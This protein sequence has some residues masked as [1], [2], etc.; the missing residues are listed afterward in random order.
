MDRGLIFR[1]LGQL[2]VAFT[3]ILVIPLLAALIEDFEHVML[4][5]WSILCSGILA[6]IFLSV[7]GSRT[8]Q[9]LR[10]REAVAVVGCGWLLVC[11]LGALPYLWGGILDPVTAIFESVSGFTTT[12][13]TTARSFEEFPKSILVWRCLTHWCGGI[14]VIMLFIIIMPQVNGGTGTMFNAEMPGGFAE[15]TLPRIRKSAAMICGVYFIMT[16]IE[17][18]LLLLG[19]VP[20]YQAINLALATMA[21]GGF[22]YYHA[23]LVSFHSVYVEI[24]AIIFMLIASMNFSLYYR[25]FQGDWKFIRDESEYK[26]YLGV[27]ALASV[28]LTANLYSSNYNNYS[29]GQCLRYGIFHAVSIGS[30]TGF[31]ADDFNNW[32]SFSRYVLFM[33]MFIGGCSGSTAG[34]IKISRMV[35]LAKAAWSELLRILHPNIIYS[36]KFGHRIVEPQRVGNITRFFFLYI[37]VFLILTLAISL[38][39]MGI[40]DSMGLIAA[41]LSSVGP[42]FGIVGPTSTYADLSIYGR[43]VTIIAMILGRLEI[44]TLL[45]IARPSFWSQKRNW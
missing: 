15:R 31:A 28:C 4:F 37:I 1:L 40:M 39:G 43:I 5:V 45:I 13:V 12:G 20:V 7:G 30:T 16:C 23:D 36:I 35:V 17:L 11:L 9:R 26:Y 6:F 38:T 2:S 18:F 32:P 22:S 3:G 33:L 14:G 42:A 24:V 41:C 25:A 21:T 27:L 29:F 34:G 19:S 10:T 8:N 44:F